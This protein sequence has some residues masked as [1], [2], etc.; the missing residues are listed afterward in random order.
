MKKRNFL[1]VI[2]LLILGTSFCQVG[3]FTGIWEGKLKFGV[4]L[5]IVF[6]IKENDKG[7]L[8]SSADSPDQA[9]FGLKCDTTILYDDKITIEMKAFKAS[10]T[11][12]LLNDST[13]EGTFFQ[14]ASVPLVLKKVDK[15]SERRRPQTPLPPFPYKSEDIEYTNADKSL[16][17][18]ATITI[19]KD[20]GPFPAAVMITGS[21][22]QNRDEEIMGH[23]LF[24]VIADYLTRRGFIILRVDDRGVGKSTGHFAGATSADFAN[25]VNAG[26]DYLL[27]IPEV[28]KKR[29]GLIGHSEGGMIAPMVATQRKDIDFIVLLAGP[30]VK[31]IDLM[32]EQN[33]AVLRSAGIS[34][35]A[36][37]SY[38]SLYKTITRQIIGSADSTTA[39]AKVKKT[40]NDWT[41]GTDA[42]LIKELDMEDAARRDTIAISLVQTMYSPWFRYFLQFDPAVYLGKIKCKVLAINGD[43]DI[44]VISKQNLPG[45]EASLK[46]NHVKHYSIREIPGLNHL[47][48]SCKKCTLEEY[49][50]LEETFSPIALQIMGDWL[51]KNVR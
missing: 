4:E 45:I 21:G 43:K 41:S 13:I 37:N 32:A 42:S 17:Y 24:A 38:S 40:M 3:K 31:I 25:D 27:T 36:T 9:A 50:E 29:M 23:K 47:F 39:L 28:D 2:S 33:A 7:S 16:R 44:Q 1:S 51:E 12:S 14:S 15:I 48:Q 46:K 6:H 26:V 5:R 22:A 8:I 19:P 34:E 35:K 20:K 11:G 10:F 18:G 30:G 49:G